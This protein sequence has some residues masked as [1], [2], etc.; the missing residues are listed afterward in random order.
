MVKALGLMRAAA[1]RRLTHDSVATRSPRPFGHEVVLLHHGSVRMDILELKLRYF[2]R[3]IFH[4]LE[5]SNFK[6]V[7]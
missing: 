7:V 6:N 4:R 3:L 1:S 5:N 2:F